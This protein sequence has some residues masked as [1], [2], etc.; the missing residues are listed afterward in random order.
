MSS[1]LRERKHWL[2][3]LGIWA[4]ATALCAVAGPFGTHDALAALPRFSYWAAITALS[5]FGSAIV[6]RVTNRR[7][8]WKAAVV[9]SGF[10]GVLSGVTHI[11]NSWL[12]PDWTGLDQ[13]IYLLA[14]TALVILVVH[15]T[16]ALARYAFAPRPEAALED[17][18]TAFLRRLPLDRRGP[19]IRLEA[20]DHYLN[21]VTHKGSALVLL[22]LQDAVHALQDVDGLQVH[23]SHWVAKDAVTRHLRVQGRDFLVLTSGDEIPVSRSYREAVQDA[24]LI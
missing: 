16:V 5:V 8:R 3:L 17:P 20:Q 24:G 7:A 19:L 10:A 6:V 4:L 21:V 11:L 2:I 15:G 13:L 9:W 14:I 18:Q 23:R 1:T 22:R 12:F